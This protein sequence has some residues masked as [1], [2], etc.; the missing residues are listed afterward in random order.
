M[1]DFTQS[2]ISPALKDFKEGFN[3][4][5]NL[6]DYHNKHS[7]LVFFGMYGQQDVNV[8]LEH[9][10]PKIVVWG[11]NDMHEGQLNLVK[12]YVDKG[13]A[14]TFAPPGE[15]SDTLNRYKIK[16]KICYIPNKDYSMFTPT[17]LGEN[18]YIYMGRPDNPRPE[19][20]K[21]NEIVSPL[22]QVF[23]KDRVKWVIQNESST[24]PMSELIEKYY[25]DCFVFVKPHERGGA[26]SMYD[27]AHMGRKTIGK[28]EVNLPNFI[29]YSDLNNLIEL[30]VEEAKYIGKVR[31]DVANGLKNHFLGNEWLDLN[32]WND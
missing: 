23:G 29:E 27:L 17:P 26:T 2:Y 22:V 7:P 32:F 20:F 19:Y 9:K 25:N 14:Y 18:I 4:K 15:F 13:K 10:G 3:K 12:N 6:V 21:Y 24:L 8:F 30:I 16:H 31:E 1:N 5:W 11:G 28:G